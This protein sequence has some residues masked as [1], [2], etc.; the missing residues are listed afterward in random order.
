M[1]HTAKAASVALQSKER[2]LQPGLPDLLKAIGAAAHAIQILRN[3]GV[4]VV[5]QREPIEFLVSV[6][7]RS[8]SHPQA[9]KAS[10]NS[11]LASRRADLPR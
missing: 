7:T 3:D 8:R 10:T 4:I 5:R 6:I 11:T 2:M 9:D 1:R